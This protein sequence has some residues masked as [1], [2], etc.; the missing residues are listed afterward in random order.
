MRTEIDRVYA[1]LDAEVQARFTKLRRD[2][3]VA[4]E[5]VGADA[6]VIGASLPE[7][8]SLLPQAPTIR[9]PADDRPF[10]TRAGKDQAIRL[11]T[12]A[13]S[14]RI[15]AALAPV[16]DVHQALVASA[17]RLDATVAGI[18]ASLAPVE[19]RVR[20]LEDPIG[21]ADRQLTQL[22]VPFTWIPVEPRMFVLF[23]PT[24]FAALVALSALRAVR[25]AHLRARLRA[26]L[27]DRGLSKEQ[28][29]LA[30]AVP[31]ATMEPP[32]V[33]RSRALLVPLAAVAVFLA[34]IAWRVALSPAFG[35]RDVVLFSIP[36]AALIAA[37]L[38][39]AMRRGA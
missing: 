27:E 38:Y 24:V 14:D 11:E 36:G 16:R 35:A 21:K 15:E 7:T 10:R 12:A 8:A 37:A 31:D 6:G 34:G 17:T 39:L 22:S 5:D 25:L 30:T 13:I 2:I 20:R 4:L 32:V 9:R 18:K 19:E 1:Q 3:A 33:P 23:Y 28:V 29:A 26:R